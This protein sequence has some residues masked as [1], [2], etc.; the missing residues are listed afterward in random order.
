MQMVAEGGRK[1]QKEARGRYNTGPCRNKTHQTIPETVTI[2]LSAS[3]VVVLPSLHL[4]A[5]GLRRNGS[6]QSS[7]NEP[8]LYGDVWSDGHALHSGH[9]LSL[10]CES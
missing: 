10:L 5:R 6:L 4:K 7:I 3:P 2:Y 9:F 1:R 8:L